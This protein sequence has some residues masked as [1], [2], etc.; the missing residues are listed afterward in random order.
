MEQVLQAVH[1]HLKILFLV[2]PLSVTL[3]D[4]L[5]KWVTHLLGIFQGCT[6]SRPYAPNTFRGFYL[7]CSG[8]MNVYLFPQYCYVTEAQRYF[9][10]FYNV[11]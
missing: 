7:A 10:I 11:G 2:N 5:R 9:A 4:D 6:A 3:Q 1:P 8:Y